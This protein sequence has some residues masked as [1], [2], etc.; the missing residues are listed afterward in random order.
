MTDNGSQDDVSA[1]L[2]RLAFGPGDPAADGGVPRLA[3]GP[4]EGARRAVPPPRV[5]P[6]PVVYGGAPGWKKRRRRGRRLISFVFVLGLVGGGLY[7]ARQYMLDKVVWDRDVALRA[8]EVSA[9]MGLVFT[10]DVPVVELPF[11]EYAAASALRVAEDD[12]DVRRSLAG[13]WR[14]LGLVSGQFDLTA[15]ASAAA[16]ETPAF[17]DPVG[18]RIVMVEDLPKALRSFALDRALGALLVDQHRHWSDDLA[19]RP[20]SVQ[21]GSRA[22]AE[23]IALESAQSLL[24][25]DD[26]AVVLEQMLRL[27]AD[28]GAPA[29]PSPYATVLLGR[30]GVAAWPV[31]GWARDAADWAE[32]ID[33]GTWLDEVTTEPTVSD[34]Q[35]LDLARLLGGRVESPGENS[36]GMLY[37]YHVLAARLD[38]DEAW[39]V[40]SLW[41]DDRVVV[42][43]SGA[44]TCVSAEFSVGSRDLAV[45]EDAITRWA[46]LAP[47]ES[48]AMVSSEAIT[49]DVGVVTLDACDPGVGAVTS[50][51]SPVVSLGAAPLRAEQF[52][53]ILAAD[54]ARLPEAVACQVGSATDAISIADDRGVLDGPDGWPAVDTHGDPTQI[55]LGSC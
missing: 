28:E 50:D 26:R 13:E 53:R 9:A 42:R 38:D 18:R 36:R 6:A 11:T 46:A 21:V 41:R 39:K 27:A 24:T 55:S 33:D 19:E 52:R 25:A 12:A 29:S 47:A 31:I 22:L 20:W 43:D 4:P 10:D 1:E 8:D 5:S 34:A 48:L 54:T 14:A 44:T 37:W 30:L 51:G 49:V 45:A 2:D 32:G 23:A 15:A 40:A 3:S 7:V 35:V 17:Y 16:I